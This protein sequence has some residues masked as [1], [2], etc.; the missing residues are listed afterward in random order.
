MGRKGLRRD[1][2]PRGAIDGTGVITLA[3]WD[4]APSS[5]LNHLLHYLLE[6]SSGE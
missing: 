6:E 5:L 3:D 2:P 4:V 1:K